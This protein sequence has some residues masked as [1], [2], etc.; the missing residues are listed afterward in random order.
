M[1][2]QILLYNLSKW[3]DMG[4]FWIFDVPQRDPAWILVKIGRPSGSTIG[5]CLEHS[6]FSTPDKSAL[7][8]CCMK[9]NYIDIPEALCTN[10]T[11]KKIIDPKSPIILG[12][13]DK[14]EN[15]RR[16][17]DLGTKNEGAARDKY[18][19]WRKVS[20]EEIGYAVSKIHPKIG[21]SIDGD[22]REL[23]G[24]PTEGI[25]EIKSPERMYEPIKNHITSVAFINKHIGKIPKT[26]KAMKTWKLK[27]YEKDYS[28]IWQTHYDQMQL[29]MGILGKLWCDY[30]VDSLDGF[31]FIKRVYFNQEYWDK[32][33][34]DTDIFIRDKIS[35]LLNYLNQTKTE[36]ILK[37]GLKMD[38]TAYLLQKL[39]F[40]LM[41]P[42]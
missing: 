4:K 27:I 34:L 12:K 11:V 39:L 35:P 13:E 32:M 42:A 17:M 21:V 25:V 38:S 8:I 41:P 29:G 26:N 24:T 18:I 22:V 5:Y 30:I 16:V 19:S 9:Y 33:M 36:D 23:D 20:C 31:T 40:P 2:D 28:Y 3:K 15:S 37:F 7:D 1:S 14:S 6:K 10:S